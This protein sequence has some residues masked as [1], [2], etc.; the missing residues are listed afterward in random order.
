MTSSLR[1]RRDPPY[2]VRLG[3]E[4]E[5]QDHVQTEQHVQELETEVYGVKAVLESHHAIRSSAPQTPRANGSFL[6]RSGSPFGTPASM[7]GKASFRA[8]G[9]EDSHLS[10]VL[11]AKYRLGGEFSLDHESDDA[12]LGLSQQQ[13]IELSGDSSSSSS[14]F[15]SDSDSDQ[16][17]MTDLLMVDADD[18]NNRNDS[19]SDL[20]VRQD[21]NLDLDSVMDTDTDMADAAA[22]RA[23]AVP[24]AAATEPTPRLRSASVLLYGDVF[25]SSSADDTYGSPSTDSPSTDDALVFHGGS[26]DSSDG[27][28]LAIRAA[29]PASS[30]DSGSSM[31]HLD[32]AFMHS[33]LSLPASLVVIFSIPK[34]R[35]TL[36]STAS[37]REQR[38]TRPLTATMYEKTVETSPSATLASII[39]INFNPI[40]RFD[41]ESVLVYCLPTLQS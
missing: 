40:F 23:S 4:Q 36:V 38:T 3:L 13:P 37:L 35:S 31:M 24:S 25:A 22:A 20:F 18:D 29:S 28:G 41:N 14:L 21:S 30:A 7:R 33:P 10:F 12:S 2:R 19:E 6:G 34:C 15:S 27:V 11:S 16:E 5:K 9:Q 8:T 32:D 39:D 17:R 26:S 1:G